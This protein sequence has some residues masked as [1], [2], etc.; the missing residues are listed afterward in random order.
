MLRYALFSVLISKVGAA[1]KIKGVGSLFLLRLIVRGGAPLRRE[2]LGRP[3]GE[4]IR[5]GVHG[6]TRGGREDHEKRPLSPFRRPQ[7][8]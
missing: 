3:D 1:G 7:F 8:F 5:H 4:A 6:A 2:V